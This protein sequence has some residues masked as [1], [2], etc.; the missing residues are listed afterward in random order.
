MEASS[1]GIL[2]GCTGA[3][4]AFLGTRF[5]I[6]KHQSWQAAAAA[7]ELSAKVRKAYD[8]LFLL[9]LGCLILSLA[10]AGIWFIELK[11]YIPGVLVVFAC[12]MLWKAYRLRSALMKHVREAN[13]GMMPGM[14]MPSASSKEGKS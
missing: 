3:A 1:V 5:Y 7:G 14:T 4:V 9:R 8:Q 2:F 6:R 10:A 13:H 12:L 11:P